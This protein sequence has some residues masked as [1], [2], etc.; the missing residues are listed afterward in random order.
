MPVVGLTFDQMNIYSG[1]L[2]YEQLAILDYSLEKQIV[3]SL[4]KITVIQL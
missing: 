2:I 4:E 3:D 1:M